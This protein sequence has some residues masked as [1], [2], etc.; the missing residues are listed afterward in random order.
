MVITGTITSWFFVGS[1]LGAMVF[2]WLM[3][4]L[5]ESIN[6]IAIMYIITGDILLAGI[7]YGFLIRLSEPIT[8]AISR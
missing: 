2:P 3:G 4:Q 5:F 6:P 1:S 7:F 8:K